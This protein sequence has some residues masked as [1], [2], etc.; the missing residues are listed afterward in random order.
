MPETA[1]QKGTKAKGVDLNKWKQVE[2]TRLK[3]KNLTELLL[4]KSSPLEISVG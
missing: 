3:A 4:T 2:S 1:P